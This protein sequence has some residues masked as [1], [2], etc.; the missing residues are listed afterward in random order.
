MNEIIRKR[1]SIRK[2]D[3]TPLDDSTLKSVQEQIEKLIPLYPGIK[4][5]IDIVKRTKGFFNIKAP[6]Y[7][8]FN[9]EDN[10]KAY[11]NIGIATYHFA[12]ESKK[13]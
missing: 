13:L 12:A 6:H 5:S 4:Y 3:L 2:Y 9:S 7:L 1:K 11:E 10:D 8:V